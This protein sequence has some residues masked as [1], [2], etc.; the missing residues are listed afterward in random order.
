DP[1]PAP[2]A[3]LRPA[4]VR[5]GRRLP[6]RRPRLGA[7]AGARRAR[8]GGRQPVGHRRRPRRRRRGVAARR[9]PRA[10]GGDGA[11]ARRRCA[12]DLV[13]RPR[14]PGGQGVARAA[15]PL[16]DLGRSGGPHRRRHR[17]R[18]GPTDRVRR[19]GPAR[20]AGRGGG[21]GALPAAVPRLGDLPEAGRGLADPSL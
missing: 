4:V 8:P 1:G 2:P 14:H 19:P 13:R 18:R 15:D 21:D 3:A 16:A 20:R 11:G 9:A 17:L 10:A 5:R 12:R 6:R 7:A